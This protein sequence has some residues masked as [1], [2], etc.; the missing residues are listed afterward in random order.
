MI[1][2]LL[3]GGVVY[4][5]LGGEGRSADVAGTDARVVAVGRDLGAARGG[6]VVDGLAMGPGSTGPGEFVALARV[7]HRW[8][9]IYTS[10]MRDEGLA[11]EAALDEA[12]DVGRRAGVRVQISHCKAAGKASHG[13]SRVLLDMIHAARVEGIDVRG[14]QYPY[15]AGGTFLNALLPADARE[16]GIAE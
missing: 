6:V 14:D 11:L 1:D 4:D 9:R 16:G 5:G 13:K 15:L 10:H 8:G 2:L 12:I 3:R 7:A